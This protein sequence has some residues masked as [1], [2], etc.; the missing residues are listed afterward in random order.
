MDHELIQIARELIE[1]RGD[2]AN[3][4]VAAA[5]RTADGRTT[6]GVNIYH[7]TGGPCAELVVIG[8]AATEGL[9]QLSRVVAVGDRDRG[10]VTPCGRC[11]QVLLDY[12]PD[13][14]VI[15]PD[16]RGD[17][18]QVPIRDLLPYEFRWDDALQAA[19][20]QKRGP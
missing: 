10:V 12:H 1:R 19:G 15:V 5:A 16:G 4:T 3:H 7:F 20:A 13:V 8:L 14:E 18:R 11:R 9:G 17:V 6:A 2:D